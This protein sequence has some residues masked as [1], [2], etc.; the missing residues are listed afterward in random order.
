LF[1]EHVTPDSIIFSAII[2]TFQVLD[3]MD[4]A[5]DN[6]EMQQEEFYAKYEPME[7]LGKLVFIFFT[8]SGY[9]T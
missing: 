1:G 8:T 7:L 3:T 6:E 5:M 2:L 9:I 4:P